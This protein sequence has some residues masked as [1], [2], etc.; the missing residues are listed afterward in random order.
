MLVDAKPQ[1]QML[2]DFL[3]EQMILADH[4]LRQIEVILDLSFVNDELKH[5][6]STEQGRPAVSPETMVRLE[7]LQYLYDLSDRELVANLQVNVAF[8]WFAKLSAIDEVIDDTT[9]CVFRKRLGPELHKRLFDRVLD[10]AR[11]E[12]WIKERRHLIDATHIRADIADRR[13]TEALAQANAILRR[14]ISRLSPSRHL[15][16][17]MPKPAHLNPEQ[18]NIESL[19]QET[20]ALITE[21]EEVIRQCDNAS[22]PLAQRLSGELEVAN[23]VLRG[24][25]HPE[26][27]ER[28]ISMVD[29]DARVG[30]KSQSRLF[31]GYKAAFIMDADSQLI[32]AVD[33][34]PGSEN[35]SEH[36]LSLVDDEIN[37]GLHPREVVADSGYA[38][39]SNRAGLS[40]RNCSSSGKMGHF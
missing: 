6:Y 12:G 20:E 30:A 10:Q 17:T 25:L 38:S 14:D 8:R 40:E 27:H 21:G 11:Q 9:L 36:M 32:T 31:I 1:R 19:V 23:A 29:P 7:L 22:S 24:V 26:E 34:V 5:L 2:G 16:E 28:T 15:P 35:D 33:V 3:F 13:P 37:R 18:D 4:P 39:G